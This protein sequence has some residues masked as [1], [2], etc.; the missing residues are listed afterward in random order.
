M[1]E[2]VLTENWFGG[3]NCRHFCFSSSQLSISFFLFSFSCFCGAHQLSKALL[4]ALGLSVPVVNSLIC[5]ILSPPPEPPSV[6]QTDTSHYERT[7]ICHCTVLSKAIW[8]KESEFFRDRKLQ[9]EM[10]QDAD[11]KNASWRVW[12]N[13]SIGLVV[14]TVCQECQTHFTSRVT[15][16]PLWY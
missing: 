13:D 10:A 3:I 14:Y 9:R 6:L 1:P 7:N 16:S 8:L 15:Y 11:S 4:N 12:K 2:T 5:A